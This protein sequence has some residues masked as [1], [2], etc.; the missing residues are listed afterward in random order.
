MKQNTKT[1]CKPTNQTQQVKSY[2]HL[3]GRLRAHIYCQSHTFLSCIWGGW[4][5][6]E[7]LGEMLAKDKCDKGL[8]SK[9]YEAEG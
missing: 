1:P 3:N 7:Q 4:K 6:R 5:V 9:V 8:T 2:L